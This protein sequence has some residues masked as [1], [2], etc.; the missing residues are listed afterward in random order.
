[1]YTASSKDQQTQGDQFARQN[2]KKK[3]NKKMIMASSPPTQQKDI[4]PA[5][6]MY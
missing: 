4:Q 5:V 1:M 3:K 2:K 6:A